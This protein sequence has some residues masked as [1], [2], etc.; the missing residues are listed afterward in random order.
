MRGKLI[1]PFY[2][3]FYDGEKYFDW[4]MAFRIRV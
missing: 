1:I 3:E 4:E 2:S